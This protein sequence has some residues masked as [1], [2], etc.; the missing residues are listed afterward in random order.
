MIAPI[1]S[2][3]TASPMCSCTTSGALP[4][5]VITM[6]WLR[7]SPTPIGMFLILMSGFA[8]SKSSITLKIGL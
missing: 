5:S 1:V 8:F 2:I 6:N 3:V 4:P 7:I